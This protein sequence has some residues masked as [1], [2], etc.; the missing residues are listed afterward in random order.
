MATL[1]EPEAPE[2]SNRHTKPRGRNPKLLNKRFTIDNIASNQPMLLASGKGSKQSSISAKR[3]NLSPQ[4]D[5]SSLSR[6]GQIDFSRIDQNLRTDYLETKMREMLAELVV[7]IVTLAKKN[8]V[9]NA[10]KNA[11]IEELR[12]TQQTSNDRID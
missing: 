11:K 7:P 6:T 10:S 9:H 5:Q 3:A 4:E 2:D 12:E 8:L 1:M